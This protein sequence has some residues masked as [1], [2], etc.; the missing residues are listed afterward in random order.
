VTSNIQR[1]CQHTAQTYTAGRQATRRQAGM[2]TS[3]E[4]GAQT[5]SWSGQQTQGSLIRRLPGKSPAANAHQLVRK[6]SL[7]APAA[8]LSPLGGCSTTGSCRCLQ[9][10]STRC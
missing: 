4:A 1:T 6:A 5:G 8:V 9:A 7:H 2:Q 10:C 3:K